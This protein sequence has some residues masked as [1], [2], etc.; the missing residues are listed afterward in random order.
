VVIIV[1][2]YFGKYGYIII[3]GL[4]VV[5]DVRLSGFYGCHGYYGYFGYY[6]IFSTFL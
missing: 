3:T 4:I 2:G 6:G 1:F 5:I